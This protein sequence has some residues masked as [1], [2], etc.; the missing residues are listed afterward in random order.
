MGTETRG[1]ARSFVRSLNILL[2][3]AR[4]YEFGHAKTSQQFETTWKELR[5]ALD[6]SGGGGVLLGASGTQILL[7]GVPLGSAAGERSF[8]QLLTSSGIASIHFS[9]TLT[10]P[11]FARFVRAF[12]SGNSKPS[13]LAE[14]LKSALAGD[15]SIK[16]NEIRYV[17]EDSSVAGIKGA[18][19]LT[20]KVLGAAGDKFRDFFEDPNKMLQMILAAES[21]RATGGGGGGMGGPGHG[22]GGAGPGFGVG[23]GGGSGGAGTGGSGTGGSGGRGGAG[24]GGGGSNLWESGG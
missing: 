16:V 22:P 9:P 7:D 14:Q 10:Q 8:A 15:N 3:F 12:P 17:A 1:G 4:L 11:Q 18:A 13:S 20:Q 6:D 24:S 5:N 23:S 21:M 19:Q 2:K